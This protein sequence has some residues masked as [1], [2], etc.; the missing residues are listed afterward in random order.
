M[1]AD[2]DEIEEKIQTVISN[3][4]G[5]PLIIAGDFNADRHTNPAGAE[6]LEKLSSYGLKIMIDV[7]TFYRGMTQSVLD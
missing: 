6:R 1:D 3:H 5:C 4:T 7:P 2:F